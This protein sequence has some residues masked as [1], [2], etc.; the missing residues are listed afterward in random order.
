MPPTETLPANG[1]RIREL[2]R[3]RAWTLEH[4]AKRVEIGVPYLSRIERGE[5]PEPAERVI[6]RLAR[7]LGVAVDEI[8]IR[9]ED[10][11]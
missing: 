11:A 9:A 1:T 4:L 8:V 10:A 3:K 6:I 7:E 5:R 2:R